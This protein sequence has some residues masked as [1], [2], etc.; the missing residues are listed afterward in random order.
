VDIPHQRQDHPN[1][2][3]VYQAYLDG[4]DYQVWYD[5]SNSSMP[6]NVQMIEI[7][8][9]IKSLFVKRERIPTSFADQIA[10]MIKPNTN[11][12][13]RLSST[14]GK[15]ERQVVKYSNADDIVRFLQTCTIFQGRE[16]KRE[17]P[18]WLILIRWNDDIS[19]SNEFR[20]FVVARKLT[21]ASPQRWWESHNYSQK[22][23]EKFESILTG[24]TFRDFLETV[25]YSSF[26]A[27]VYLDTKSRSCRLIELNPFGAHSG[28]GASLFHWL[29]D[30]DQLHH[31]SIPEM[32]YLSV[33]N[34]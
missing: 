8:A 16:F 30:Y 26:V 27:D 13:V 32:R 33:L 11:Y 6:Q 19:A 15:N 17:K 4:F 20:I 14:S 5:A 25:C 2:I 22:R 21:A 29:N 12:F 18:T 7:D 24:A 3:D 9:Y 28:A 1:L 31:A 10:A 23:L 34:I